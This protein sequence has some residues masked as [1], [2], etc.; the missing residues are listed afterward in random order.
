LDSRNTAESTNASHSQIK[1]K[2]SVVKKNVPTNCSTSSNRSSYNQSFTTNQST[3]SVSVSSESDDDTSSCQEVTV[4]NEVIYVSSDGE[5]MVQNNSVNDSATFEDLNY[6]SICKRKNIFDHD[7][8]HYNKEF[9]TCLVPNCNI[10]S[11]SLKDFTPHYRQHIGMP[12]GV[13]LCLRCF[14]ENKISERDVNGF[15]TRCCT[16]NIFKCFTCNIIFN[17]MAEFAS[18]KLK[19]HNGRLINSSGNYLCFYCEKSSPDLMK[20]NEHIKHCRENQMKNVK[21]N[22]TD[23]CMKHEE[24]QES[25]TMLL[26]DKKNEYKRGKDKK[27]P[28]SAQHL[29]FTCL[30]PSCNLIFQNFAVFKFHHREHFEIGNKLMCWQCCSPFSN[31]NGLR[32]HQ[33]KGNCR[34]PGMFKCFECTEVFN[35]LQSL[36]IHKYTIHDGDLIANKKN[37]KTI[38]CAFCKNEISIHNFKNHLVKCQYKIEKKVLP[39]PHLIKKTKYS[40]SKC[41]YCGKVCLTA[42]A[43]SSHIKI[44]SPKS[45]QK[46]D[47]RKR[48]SN[49]SMKSK[50]PYELVNTSKIEGEDSNQ[51]LSSTSQSND[52]LTSDYEMANTS[53][54]GKDMYEVI[55][56]TSSGSSQSNEMANDYEMFPFVDNYYLCIKCPKKFSSKNG[57]IKHWNICSSVS[58]MKSSMKNVP[59]NYYC[60]KCK[61]YYTR[62]SFVEHW[63]I[64]HGRRLPYHKFKRFSCTKCPF[65]FMYKIALLMHDEHVHGGPENSENITVETTH[66]DNDVMLPVISNTTSL[67]NCNAEDIERLIESDKGF[68]NGKIEYEGTTNTILDIPEEL[69]NENDHDIN[70]Q[71]NDSNDLRNNEE[72]DIS[73]NNDDNNSDY[74]DVHNIQNVDTVIDELN[75]NKNKI[76][77][78]QLP[79]EDL[80]MVNNSNEMDCKSEVITFEVNDKNEVATVDNNE[81]DITSLTE[82]DIQICIDNML[83][84]NNSQHL[85]ENEIIN[86]VQKLPI[87]SDENKETN[88][89]EGCSVI[90]ENSSEQC[91]VIGINSTEKCTDIDKNSSEECP[92]IDNNS[93]EECSVIGINSSEVTDT[94]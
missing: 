43:L 89:S 26:N 79:S 84:T 76:S 19:T 82:E 85:N 15:H 12:S 44:H 18:H 29:L 3:R 48:L 40:N 21:D 30:K 71:N 46:K 34:T 47:A 33:V 59:H 36:S 93:S 37:K 68:F 91:S 6:C 38:I 14:Q 66:S 20:M 81:K 94:N 41:V 87:S 31:L 8:S 75:Y 83:S 35:D 67:A 64:H 28:R 2:I 86:I 10:L 62:L 7:C 17:T 49:T 63:K 70:E 1:S 42:A 50:V 39:K 55:N 56:Q 32:M 53:D 22:V 5:E 24:P 88:E 73:N 9:S 90:S 57:L 54:G 60:T 74:V 69:N 65:K 25:E 4:N 52:T 23:N 45:L 51:I 78:E 16:L 13:M 92:V 58:T 61:E 27:I 77:P 11:R 80:L 72:Q